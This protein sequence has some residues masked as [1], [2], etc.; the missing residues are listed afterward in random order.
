[1]KN[2]IVHIALAVII[3]L[4]VGATIFALLPKAHPESTA[5]TTKTT[6]TTET[7]QTSPTPSTQT[8]RI[9]ETS[10]LAVTIPAG[11]TATEATQNGIANPSA[12]NITK[13][14]WILYMN[15]NASQASGVS[16]GRFAEIGMGAPSV[17][18]VVLDEPNE[19]GTAKSTPA[20]GAFS[21]V[22]LSVSAADAQQWCSVPTNGKTVW[23]FS[24]LTKTGIG[25]YFNDYVADQNPALVVTMAYE[26]DDVKGMN[27]LPPDATNSG[28]NNLPEMGSADLNT[29]LKAMTD[30]ASTLTIKNH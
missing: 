1:M 17:D 15:V 21:R 18:A 3:V 7:P 4:A 20:F 10:E 22:D 12:V 28:V 19:C 16:G 29:A 13:G 24:Y 8:S 26:I 27:D 23:F 2:P 9:Y 14:S 30:I 6:N 11:W 5:S 25:G